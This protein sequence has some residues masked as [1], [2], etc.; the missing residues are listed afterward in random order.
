M[1]KSFANI[2]VNISH[3]ALDRIFQ[4]IIP[5]RLKDEIDVGSYV[6][7]PFGKGN[8]LINGYVV[9]ITDEPEFDLSRQKE[10]VKLESDP[11]I[12]ESYFIKIAA[13]MKKRY[14][15][16]MI[17][18]LKTVLP[19]KQKIKEKN[20]RTI[21]LLLDEADCIERLSFYEKKHQ[22][23]RYRLLKELL[24]Y[25]ELDYSLVTQKLSV[26]KSTIDAMMSQ[27]IVSVSTKR[28][29]RNSVTG[30]ANAERKVLNDE[31]RKVADSI[32]NSYRDKNGSKVHLIRGVTGSGK[33]EIYMEVIDEVIK[34]GRQAIVLIPEIALTYQ[35]VMRFYKRYGDRVSTLHSK[36]SK[37]EKDDQFVRAKNGEIDVMIGPRSAL[38]TPFRN[39]GIIVIDEEH[40]SSYKSDSMPKYHARE[41]AEEI[42]KLNNALLVLGSATPSLTAYY[43][44][45][46]K[47]IVLHEIDNR[48]NNAALAKVSVVDLRKEM[49]SGN[50]SM[51][52]E[53]LKRKIEDRL[54]KNEQVMLFLN[55]R[56]MSSFISC[57]SCGYVIKC[58]HCDVSLTEHKGGKMMCHYCGYT[59]IKVKSCPECGSSYIGGM[60]AGTEQVE[61]SIKKL[62]PNATVL[63]MDADTTKDKDSYEKILSAFANKEADILVGTQM[64]VKGHDFPSVTLVGVLLADM[65]LYSNDYRAS[66]RTFELITQAVGRAGRGGVP[67]EA[68]I[69]TYSPEDYC[70]VHSANQDYKAFYED[71][72]SYRKMMNY[73]PVGHMFSI[74]LECSDEKYLTRFAD[75]L[76]EGLKNDIIKR[77][78]SDSVSIIGPTDASISKINDIYRK[79][80]YLKAPDISYLID[81]KDI[82]QEH[83]KDLTRVRVTFDMDPV[84]G[85]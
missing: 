47:E 7:I 66:E 5:D 55:R 57:R 59:S 22:R 25:K 41:V 28:I 84:N 3:E 30:N 85:C 16:T 10:I 1:L 18:A 51:F 4:Y 27:G 31:Q 49:K 13:F 81:E 15:S 83:T 45:V 76:A 43:R 38:F 48:A 67:G 32:I 54:L 65:S 58:P 79:V 69:Q 26:S 17:N 46:N 63:R 78:R 77:L 9:E 75:N 11:Q 70:I 39:L 36:L 2:I 42:A 23:A 35:T 73:P 72:I 29:Y 6:Q 61:D 74:L 37:G 56:G 64:I 71:E 52:S 62:F 34:S 53:E 80:I 24:E 8:K 50:K 20:E 68:I 12:V 21:E 82:T 44:A 14:G 19:I 60:K 40:E 33:T